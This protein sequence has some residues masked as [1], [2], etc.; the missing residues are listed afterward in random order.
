MMLARH[1][2]SELLLTLGAP[3]MLYSLLLIGS[4]TGFIVFVMCRANGE[5]G[6]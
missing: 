5:G 4:F 3:S 6:Q 1:H 2:M